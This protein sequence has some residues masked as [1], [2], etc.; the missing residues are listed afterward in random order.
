MMDRLEK[1]I[2][3][4]RPN[5]VMTFAIAVVVIAWLITIWGIVLEFTK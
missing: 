3:A 1:F 4:I 5:W 2:V